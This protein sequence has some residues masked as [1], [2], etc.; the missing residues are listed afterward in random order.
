MALQLILPG[1]PVCFLHTSIKQVSI[2]TNWDLWYVEDFISGVPCGV[3]VQ[4][5]QLLPISPF[6]ILVAFCMA[7]L[8]GLFIYEITLFHEF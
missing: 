4:L 6:V 3:S 8:S 5:L 1:S 7:E 2:Q